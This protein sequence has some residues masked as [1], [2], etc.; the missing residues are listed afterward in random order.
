MPHWNFT[1]PKNGELLG[2]EV[3]VESESAKGSTFRCTLPLDQ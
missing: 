2:G 1:A 3:H